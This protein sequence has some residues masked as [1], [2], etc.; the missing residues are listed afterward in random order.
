MSNTTTVADSMVRDPI[1]AELW[2]PLSLVRQQMLAN[3]FS[4]L[5]VL[6]EDGAY[7]LVADLSIARALSRALT[8]GERRK[9]LACSLADAVASTLVEVPKADTISP[10]AQVQAALERFGC[11]L[12]EALTGVRPFAGDST[13]CTQA[14]LLRLPDMPSLDVRRFG[15]LLNR[16]I[17]SFCSTLVDRQTD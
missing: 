6:R 13:F 8:N 16:R 17:T 3:S 7:G 11:L 1:C 10:D 2:Q 15:Y 12:H 5:P 9:M 14:A 4:Y